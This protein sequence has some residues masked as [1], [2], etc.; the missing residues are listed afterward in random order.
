M[1]L[2]QNTANDIKTKTKRQDNTPVLHS[3]HWLYK[4]LQEFTDHT[5]MLQGLQ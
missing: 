5:E 2:V 3:R 1:Q 4:W